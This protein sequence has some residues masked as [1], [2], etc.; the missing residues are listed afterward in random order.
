MITQRNRTRKPVVA[1]DAEFGKVV[2]TPQALKKAEIT[3]ERVG[4]KEDKLHPSIHHFL[5][6]AAAYMLVNQIDPKSVAQAAA[7]F[8]QNKVLFM[9]MTG[10]TAADPEF[11]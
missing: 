8:K 5:A 10:T 11:L 6:G 4:L 1:D 7:F 2:L 9:R 3:L